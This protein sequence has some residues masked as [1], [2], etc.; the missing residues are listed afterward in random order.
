MKINTATKKKL[1]VTSIAAVVLIAGFIAYNAPRQT[2]R[3]SATETIQNPLGSQTK[4]NYDPPTKEEQQAGNEQ[5]QEIVDQQAARSQPNT[6][7]VVIADASQYDNKVEVRAFV[8]NVIQDGTCTSTFT[9][10]PATVT[11][12]V[13]ALKDAKTTRC[14]NVTIPKCEFASAGTWGRT[15]TYGSTTA[16]GTTNKQ[17]NLEEGHAWYENKKYL[18]HPLDYQSFRY[19]CDR[20]YP[21]HRSRPLRLRV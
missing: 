8:T 5:K 1:L 15:V 12:T 17:I 19:S 9:R 3:S 7:T 20:I 10:G 14:T 18:L 13:V 16:E 4:I 11:R 2:D 6:A 21:F